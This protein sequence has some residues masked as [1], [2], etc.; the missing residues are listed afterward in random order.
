MKKS[1]LTACIALVVFSACK[2]QVNQS[3]SQPCD[4]ACCKACYDNI[5]SHFLHVYFDT[6]SKLIGPL[7]EHPELGWSSGSD[8]VRGLVAFSVSQVSNMNC[9]DP[10]P[11]KYA[12]L[13]VL[14]WTLK[15]HQY[16][17]IC[18]TC[19]LTTMEQK[20]SIVALNSWIDFNPVIESSWGEARIFGECK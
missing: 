13:T 17:S 9:G 6:L 1:I 5:A 15:R 11:V 10:S 16:E 8:T 3:P 12:S 2:K 4:E 7:K 19:A 20:D 18:D 14:Q